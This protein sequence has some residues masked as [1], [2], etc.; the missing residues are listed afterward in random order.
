MKVV[1]RALNVLTL[2]GESQTGISLTEAS[3]RLEYPLTTLHRILKVL[4]D[5]EFVRRDSISLAYYPGRRLQRIASLARRD[6][7]AAVSRENLQR[8]SEKFNETAMMT[9]LIDERAV[10]IALAES[11]RPLH[12]SVSVGQ[13]VPLH[14]AASARVLYSGYDDESVKFLLIE[15]DFVPLRPRTPKDVDDV[16][17]NLKGIRAN[18]YDVCDN[19]FDEGIWAVAAPIHDASGSVIAGITL[20]TPQE[21]SKTRQYR[22]RVVKEVVASAQ[23]ISYAIGGIPLLA[24]RLQS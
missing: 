4:L 11:R 5:E 19:E 20:T 15:H 17:V 13:A 9:Q 24:K 6:T 2:I 8:L 10:C 12:L 14:A 7:L 3:E 18:G 22:D 16:I 1:V 21:R 23:D